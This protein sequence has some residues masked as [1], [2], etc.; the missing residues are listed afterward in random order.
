MHGPSLFDHQNG[1]R[2]DGLDL[3]PQ[4][5]HVSHFRMATKPLAVDDISDE[6]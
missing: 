2:L 4:C 1:V 5:M 6:A 3:Y